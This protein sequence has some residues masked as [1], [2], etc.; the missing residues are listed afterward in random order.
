PAREYLL[1]AICYFLLRTSFRRVRSCWQHTWSCIQGTCCFAAPP[2]SS[3][4]GYFTPGTAPGA[5]K[6]P[7]EDRVKPKSHSMDSKATKVR[8]FGQEEREATEVRS[9]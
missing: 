8:H 2:A 9:P 7:H 4:L 1:S 6:S 3:L 5:N